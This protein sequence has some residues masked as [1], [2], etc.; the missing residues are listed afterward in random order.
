M[1]SDDTGSDLFRDDTP[2]QIYDYDEPGLVY[3]FD[4][5]TF[6]N[7]F[8]IKSDAIQY[9]RIFVAYKDEE[10]CSDIIA[11]Q[12]EHKIDSDVNTNINAPEFKIYKHDATLQINPNNANN[13]NDFYNY[14]ELNP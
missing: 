5:T 3:V 6:D 7:V 4:K 13:E 10:R 8:N 12:I 9:F 14:P 1:Y 2:P 11:Y